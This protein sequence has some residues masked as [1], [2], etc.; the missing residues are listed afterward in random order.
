[1]ESGGGGEGG[2][3]RGEDCW[4]C[5]Q[6]LDNLLCK[7]LAARSGTAT[8][9][10]GLCHPCLLPLLPLVL[11]CRLCALWVLPRATSPGPAASTET[12]QPAWWRWVHRKLLHSPL[13]PAA[14]L[15]LRAAAG[16]VLRRMSTSFASGCPPAA[17]CSCLQA[18]SAAGVQQFVLVTSLGTGKIGWPAGVLNLFGGVLIFKRKAE[19]ALEAS[20]LPYVIVR[21]GAAPLA[22]LPGGWL[23]GCRQAAPWGCGAV[24]LLLPPALLWLM[25]DLQRDLI[26]RRLLFFSPFFHHVYCCLPLCAG[27]MERPR[28]DY[29][30]TNN[31]RLATRDK[32]F[33]GQVS[34][35]QVSTCLC[36]QACVHARTCPAL[37]SSRRRG[38][39]QLIVSRSCIGQ[40]ASC[41]SAPR[42][43]PRFLTGCCSR[44]PCLWHPLPAGG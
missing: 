23:E 10:A 9:P 34:R 13:L 30:L 33:G 7:K 16:G 21:P 31:M 38:G 42:A 36:M 5:A 1:M 3:G 26:T 19:E 14:A 43:A 12:A 32:L 15:S 6:H 2:G 40:R 28:D 29:K 44:C 37:G 41:L 22:G 4:C 8:C 11:P 20:G 39:C 25:P 27:G 35:L 24:A 17:R 18:A